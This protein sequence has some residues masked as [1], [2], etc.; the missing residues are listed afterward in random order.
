VTHLHKCLIALGAIVIIGLFWNLLNDDLALQ[1]TIQVTSLDEAVKAVCDQHAY[2][3]AVHFYRSDDPQFAKQDRD[4][5]VIAHRFKVTNRILSV[6]IAKL[7]AD[8]AATVKPHIV[9]APLN[10][11]SDKKKL[12][13]IAVLNTIDYPLDYDSLWIAAFSFTNTRYTGKGKYDCR[14]AVSAVWPK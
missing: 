10:W 14:D 5:Q 7:P 1:P 12:S 9:A 13:Y 11:D 6:D 3:F 2:G 4:L 8:Q